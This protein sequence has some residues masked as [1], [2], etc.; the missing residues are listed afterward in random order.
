MCTDCSCSTVNIETAPPTAEATTATTYSVV[1]MTCGGCASSVSAGIGKLDGVTS[2]DV[3]V[4][5][6]T[7]AVRSSTPLDDEKVRAAVEGAGY[8]LATV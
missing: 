2:V 6:G 4:A 8:Q 1:G 5:T 7:V 3:D